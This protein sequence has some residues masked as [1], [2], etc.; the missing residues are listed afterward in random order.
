ME[1]SLYFIATVFTTSDLAFLLSRFFVARFYK[2]AR[3]ER[4]NNGYTEQ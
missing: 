1:K 3:S 4:G 2:F